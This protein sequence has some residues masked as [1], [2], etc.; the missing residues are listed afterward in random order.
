MYLNGFGGVV[1][2]V[3]SLYGFTVI[4]EGQHVRWEGVLTIIALAI[5]GVCAISVSTMALSLMES[6]KD[7]AY[8]KGLLALKAE[9]SRLTLEQ[10]IKD[11]KE[12]TK[13]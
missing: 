6:S 7:P 5:F 9:K 2:L 3:F 1:A 4:V 11:L 10:E 13:D 8:E 12:K